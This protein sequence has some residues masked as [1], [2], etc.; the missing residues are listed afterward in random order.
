MIKLRRCLIKL[1]QCLLFFYRFC[2]FLKNNDYLCKQNGDIDLSSTYAG[3][4]YY[5]RGTYLITLVVS[6]REPLLSHFSDKG[7]DALKGDDILTLTLLGEVVEQTG[8]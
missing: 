4:D 6:G 7:R 2:L 8:S 3:H 1:R 5:G